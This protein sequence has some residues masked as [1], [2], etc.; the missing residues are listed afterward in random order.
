M[1]LRL[2][3]VSTSFSATGVSAP[4][5][6]ALTQAPGSP[7]LLRGGFAGGISLLLLSFSSPEGP[8]AGPVCCLHREGPTTHAQVELGEFLGQVFHGKPWP[9]RHRPPPSSSNAQQ[10]HLRPFPEVSPK[11]LL[12]QV[13]EKVKGRPQE[14][15][16]LLAWRT[17]VGDAPQRGPGSWA[18][19]KLRQLWKERC[20]HESPAMGH[21]RLS[22]SAVDRGGQDMAGRHTDLG[23]IPF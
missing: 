3:A 21:S 15:G 12:G 1:M 10:N 18:L 8:E 19:T 7:R 13:Q 16:Q 9:L 2:H 22:S 11:E 14:T 23:G 17:R 4:E 5:M 20:P 6:P